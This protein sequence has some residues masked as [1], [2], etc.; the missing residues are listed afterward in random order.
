MKEL[1]FPWMHWHSMSAEMGDEALAPDDPL[2]S[3]P[4]YKERA[5]AEVLERA[6]VRPGIVLW[7]RARLAKATAADGTPCALGKMKGTTRAQR[8]HPRRRL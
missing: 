1:K 6:V 3:E 5:K 7:N 4:L 2:R 8:P